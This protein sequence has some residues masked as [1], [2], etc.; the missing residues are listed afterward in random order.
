MRGKTCDRV[1]E[2]EV[3]KLCRYP[4]FKKPSVFILSAN[5]AQRLHVWRHMM[6]FHNI[7]TFKI[8]KIQ[9]IHMEIPFF[10]IPKKRKICCVCVCEQIEH[11]LK[12]LSVW[13][14]VKIDKI[15]SVC[16]FLPV[17]RR[18][19]RFLNAL[20]VLAIMGAIF[21]TSGLSRPGVTA[22]SEEREE[23]WGGLLWEGG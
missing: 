19:N 13:V 12:L 20:I 4:M 5:V 18:E 3:T 15:Y 2:S 23:P 11:K 7:N 16:Y 17:Y 9:S 8:Q 1:S 21:L 22:P 14:K 10:S 6:M